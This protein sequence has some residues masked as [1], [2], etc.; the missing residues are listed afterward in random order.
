MERVLW[1]AALV[2]DLRPGRKGLEVNLNLPFMK[3][4]NCPAAASQ[5]RESGPPPNQ[6][7]ERTP[8]RCAR[9]RRSSAR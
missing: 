6:P 8:P 9:L 7:M 5:E 2:V 1:I 4:D 3:R